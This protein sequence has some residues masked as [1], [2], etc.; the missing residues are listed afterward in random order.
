MMKKTL[1]LAAL[2]ICL[3]YI[4]NGQSAKKSSSSLY[5]DLT[6]GWA[7][8]EG[9]FAS[10]QPPAAG[11]AKNGGQ[12]TLRFGYLAAKNF[13]L[14]ADYSVAQFNT[15]ENAQINGL[16]LNKWRYSGFSFGPSIKAPMGSRFEADFLLKGG[17]AL[18]LAAVPEATNGL[19]KE[20]RTATFMLKPGFDLRYHINDHFF[21]IG[22]ID[23]VFMNPKFKHADGSTLDQQISAYH[24]GFGAG[25]RF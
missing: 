1:P 5:A 22:D 4:A 14:E 24:V 17:I 13:A 21:I 16:F 25:V 7:I 10:D 8:P 23:W 20:N 9:N 6:Y 19:V 3:G 2:L 15:K 12:F 11:Y 18:V